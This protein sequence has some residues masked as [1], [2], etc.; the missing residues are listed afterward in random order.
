VT[1]VPTLHSEGGTNN[2]TIYRV[3]ARS[4]SGNYGTPDYVSRTVFA[5]F[6]SVP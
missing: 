1:C 3:T 4:Q 5:T 2:V 6:S